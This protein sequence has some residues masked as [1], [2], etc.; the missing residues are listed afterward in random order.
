M[1]DYK[2][3]AEEL[4][5]AENRDAALSAMEEYFPNGGRDYDNVVALYEALLRGDI[6]LLGLNY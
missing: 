1:S 4:Y 2:V 3:T 5:I 6:P